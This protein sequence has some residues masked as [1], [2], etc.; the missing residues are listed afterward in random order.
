MIELV[1]RYDVTG[2]TDDEIDAIEDEARAIAENKDRHPAVE[3]HVD[4]LHRLT[5]DPRKPQRKRRSKV[6]SQ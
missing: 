2:L 5:P 1:V 3:C 6:G 4:Q